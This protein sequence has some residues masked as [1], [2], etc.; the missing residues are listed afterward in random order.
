MRHYRATPKPSITELAQ[1]RHQLGR[2]P[3][4]TSVARTSRPPARVQPMGP[5]LRGPILQLP[6][7]IV[8]CAPLDKRQVPVPK[9]GEFIW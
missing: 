7:C 9:V 2:R 5:A 6:T 4:A 1:G 8:N 3:R